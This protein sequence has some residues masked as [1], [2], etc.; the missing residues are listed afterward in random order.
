[1]TSPTT[2]LTDDQIYE[3]GT[4][5]TRDEAGTHFTEY[6]ASWQVFEELGLIEI[7]RPVHDATGISYSCEYWGLEV[8][9]AGQALIDSRPELFTGAP[10]PDHFDVTACRKIA[11][12]RVDAVLS[13]RAEP[14]EDLLERGCSW[15]DW[16]ELRNSL[17]VGHDL[18]EL[19]EEIGDDLIAEEWE[20]QVAATLAL[21][22]E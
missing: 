19:W 20:A 16:P 9:A 8:T 15:G 6:S 13:N 17:P 14:L 5:T 12:A 4:L 3:L 2:P 1:M 18:A 11:A 22:S 10:A 21:P 7:T